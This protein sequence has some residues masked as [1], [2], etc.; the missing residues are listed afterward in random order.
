MKEKQEL[1][2]LQTMRVDTRQTDRE[3]LEGLVTNWAGASVELGV[4]Q[5]GRDGN[6]NQDRVT[7]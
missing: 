6:R 2:S 3:G 5:T 1:D 7:R 4:G